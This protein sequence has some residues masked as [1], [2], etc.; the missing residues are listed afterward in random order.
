MEVTDNLDLLNSGAEYWKC[1]FV[2]LKESVYTFYILHKSVRLQKL[3]MLK[4][5]TCR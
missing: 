3:I 1:P 4:Q 2:V 5:P